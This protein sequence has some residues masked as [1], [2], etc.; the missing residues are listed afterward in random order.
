MDN[1]GLPRLGSLSIRSAMAGCL[2][3]G[4]WN[5]AWDARPARWL[6]GRHSAWLLFGVCAC[7]SA[8]AAPL[9][10]ATSSP[11]LTDAVEDNLP[12]PTAVS[13]PE[14]EPVEPIPVIPQ[15]EQSG[16]GKEIFSDYTVTG[17]VSWLC[18]SV[19]VHF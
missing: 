15:T 11:V 8:A 19:P 2:S 5:A 3:E 10:S 17:K 14:N 4:S 6:H 7:F 9:M 16:H 18:C 13:E 12:P 1:V